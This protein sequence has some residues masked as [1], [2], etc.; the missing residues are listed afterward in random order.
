[1]VST[2]LN[3]RSLHH[4]VALQEQREGVEGGHDGEVDAHGS[5]GAGDEG[6]AGREVVWCGVMWCGVVW[7][8]CG[9]VW[10]GVVWCGVV[11]CGVV[12]CGVV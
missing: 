1:M 4:P 8:W 2:M 11:W 9:V 5:P 12:W 3:L 7:W 10:C 6:F